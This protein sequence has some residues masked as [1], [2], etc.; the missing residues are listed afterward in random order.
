MMSEN[1]MTARFMKN[2]FQELIKQ[3]RRKGGGNRHVTPPWVPEGG[4]NW[5]PGGGK[6]FAITYMIV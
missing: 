4:G 6:K 5:A 1:Q 2:T 3:R